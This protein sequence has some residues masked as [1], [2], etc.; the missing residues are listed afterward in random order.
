LYLRLPEVASIVQE[1]A[2]HAAD[3]TTREKGRSHAMEGRMTSEEE[4]A[5]RCL[6][7]GVAALTGDA[8][9]ERRHEALMEWAEGELGLARAWA[10]DVYALAEEVELEPV[11]AFLLVRC[12]IGVRELQQPV[13]DPDEEAVQQAPPDW[14]GA[15]AVTLGDA[16]LER[17]LRGTFRRMRAHLEQTATAAAAVESFLAEPDVGVVQ[18][19]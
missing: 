4:A 10:E 12:G 15:D 3:R 16:A 9:A 7:D 17:R 5:Q 11:Y 2:L 6:R 14:V 19:R 13:Q 1:H 8:A 18:L